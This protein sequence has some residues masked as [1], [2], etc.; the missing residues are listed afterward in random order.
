LIDVSPVGAVQDDVV[1][2]VELL[3]KGIENTLSAVR[4]LASVA[5]TV[6]VDPSAGADDGVPV[7]AP[8]DV[9]KDNPDGKDPETTDSVGAVP[10]SSVAVI[11]V[12]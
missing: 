7:I 4:L 8:V 2:N 11:V 9:F 3:K 10:E 6:N 1:V 5:L 12:E